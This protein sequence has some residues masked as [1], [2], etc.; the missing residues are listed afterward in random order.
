MGRGPVWGAGSFAQGCPLTRI[1]GKG[2]GEPPVRPPQSP[3]IDRSSDNR[4]VPCFALVVDV[5]DDFGII[6]IYS[7]GIYTILKLLLLRSTVVC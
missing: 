2:L 5:C 7:A 6:V 3:P 4:D 1:L